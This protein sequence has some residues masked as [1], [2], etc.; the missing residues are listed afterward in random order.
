M[1][2]VYLLIILVTVDGNVLEGKVDIYETM[3]E[4][5]DDLDNHIPDFKFKSLEISC[6]DSDEDN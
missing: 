4:C 5:I 2:N 1:F 6:Y 3:Q